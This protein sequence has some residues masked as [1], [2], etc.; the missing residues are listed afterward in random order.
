MN[1][2]RLE[3]WQRRTGERAVMLSYNQGLREEDGT[4]NS[5]K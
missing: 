2:D 5:Y 1:L 4:L 3:H